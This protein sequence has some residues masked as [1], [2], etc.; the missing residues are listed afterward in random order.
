[1]RADLLCDGMLLLAL[2]KEI[3]IIG[4]AATHTSEESRK[5][6]LEVPWRG[7]VAMRNRLIHAYAAV[8]LAIVWE[9]VTASLPAL[10][11]ELERALDSFR[12]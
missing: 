6:I 3:E 11:R 7:I 5:N 12:P 8:E 10:V 2:I 1:M 9:T 4:E